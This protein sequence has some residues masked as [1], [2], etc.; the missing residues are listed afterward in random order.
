M[1]VA[2]TIKYFGRFPSV[3]MMQASDEFD[4]TTPQG[5][6]PVISPGM[7]VFPAQSGGGVYNFHEG[8][9]EIKQIAYAGGGTLTVTKVVTDGNGT[10]LMSSVVETITSPTPANFSN[11][12]LQRNEHLAL[13]SSGGTNPKVTITGHEAAYIADGGA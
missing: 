8:P 11:L 1:A 7:Y 10:T 4:G 5:S 6:L 3:I 12:Y 9:V 13:V 2:A